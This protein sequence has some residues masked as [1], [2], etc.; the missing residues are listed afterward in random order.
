[1]AQLKIGFLGAGKMA[2]ALARG[3]INAKLVKADQLFAADPFD[4]A[5]KHFAAETGA[6]TAADNLEIARAAKVLNLASNPDLVASALAEI[7]CIDFK[8]IPTNSSSGIYN[9]DWHMTGWGDGFSVV[10][11]LKDPDVIYWESQ[12]GSI[13]RYNKKTHE[14]KD[15][16]PQPLTGEDKLRFNW[17]TPIYQST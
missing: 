7:S 10:S 3:F 1:M 16:Q 15:I 6:K 14:I 5:R 13:G 9:K 4:A 12:G 8:T 17:N 11:D 2:T